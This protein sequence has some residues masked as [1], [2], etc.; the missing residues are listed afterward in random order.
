MDKKLFRFVMR[1]RTLLIVGLIGLAFIPLLVSLSLNFPRVLTQFRIAEENRQLLLIQGNTREIGMEMKWYQDSLRILS[2][3]PGAVELV[4][5]TARFFPRRIVERRVGEMMVNWYQENPEVLSIRL[6][7]RQGQECYA[8]RRGSDG[9]LA[10]PP[11][12]DQSIDSLSSPIALADQHPEGGVFYSGFE[13]IEGVGGGMSPVVRLAVGLLDQGKAVGEACLY[14]DL[15]SLIKRYA[16]C[17]IQYNQEK[18]QATPLTA[19]GSFGADIELP[20]GADLVESRM[21]TDRAGQSWALIPLFGSGHFPEHVLLVHPLKTGNTMVWVQ[22]WRREMIILFSFLLLLVCLLAMKLAAVIDASFQEL[23]RA[24]HSLLHKQQP[25]ALSWSGPREV[26]S[27]SRNLNSLSQQYIESLRSQEKMMLETQK[28]ERELRQSQK[29]K[30]LGLLAGGV[31]HDLNNILSGIVSYPQLLLLQ[32]SED[33]E[34]RTPIVEIQRS[35][36]RAAAVVADLLTVARGVA[37]KKEWCDLNALTR[38]YLESPECVVLQKNYAEVFWSRQFCPEELPVICSPVHVK[39]ALMNLVT[40]AVESVK[41]GGQIVVSTRREQRV[42]EEGQETGLLVS[43][44]AVLQVHDNGP[45]IEEK[46]LEHIFEPFYSKK[47]MGRSG[48]GIGLTVVWNTMS[49]HDGQVKVSSNEEGSCF[50]LYFPSYQGGERGQQVIRAA[51]EDLQGNGES[52]LVIDDEPQQRDLATRI[53]GVYGYRVESVASGEE[54][55]EF[56]RHQ[57]CDLLLLDMIMD[58]GLNGYETYRQILQIRP[59]QMAIIVSGFSESLNVEET[60]NLG[61]T[62]FIRKPYSMETLARAV[63]GALEKKVAA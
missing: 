35:G 30:A 44:Y 14:L 45:G 57:A 17:L 55:V 50:E 25:L 15:S 2:F 3:S 5:N 63:K 29:M 46:D 48:T 9:L 27:L 38:E 60:K 58:P 13:W 62:D 34:L 19:P 7:D 51:A 47:K 20:P 12:S 1:I 28:M 33:S 18:Q 11:E 36:E 16:G 56:L 21:I 53:L 42:A 24:V 40:N 22:K 37:S 52:I 59:Q 26:K 31:A 8:L 10:V 39:K 49:D 6:F 32:L 54:A 61:A 41:E 43:D 4:S 23:F